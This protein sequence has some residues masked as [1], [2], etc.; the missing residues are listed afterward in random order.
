VNDYQ[1]VEGWRRTRS[2]PEDNFSEEEKSLAL[3]RLRSFSEKPIS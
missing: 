1:A 3:K 2:Y